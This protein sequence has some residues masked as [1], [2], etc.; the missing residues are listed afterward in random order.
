M[1]GL[2]LFT[3]RGIPVHVNLWFG[4]LLLWYT[5]VSGDVVSG[6]LFG[7][8]VF[9]SLL[10]H[11]FGHALMAARYRLGPSILLHGLGGLTSHRPI[12]SP[13]RHAL[14]VAAGPAAG[15]VLAGLVYAASVALGSAAP[16]LLQRPRVGELVTYMLYINVFWTAI[17]LL[18]LH[19]LDGGQL[20]ELGV[21][22]VLRGQPAR[23]TRIVHGVGLGIALVA[24]GLCAY[25]GLLFLAVIAALL[26]W[27]NYQQLQAVPS[28][29]PSREQK[30]ASRDVLAGAREALQSGDTREAVRLAHIARTEPGLSDRELASTREL[31]VVAAH[32][33]GQHAEAVRFFRLAPRNARTVTAVVGSLIALDRHDEAR[34]LLEEHRGALGSAEQRALEEQL[35]SS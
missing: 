9:I 34:D 28:T 23:A 6:I 16:E 8:C 5:W 2:H 10:V 18:P 24:T 1:S 22:R 21:H 19:P 32:R 15:L 25:A 31:I 17:N 12:S 26:A 11:E 30:R 35:K 20:F 14:I 33:D 3:I 27:S 13:G 4:L 7:L 29:A